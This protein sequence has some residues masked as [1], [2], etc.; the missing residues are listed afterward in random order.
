MIMEFSGIF[1]FVCAYVTAVATPGPG[2]AA[3]VARALGRGLQGIAPFILGF[4]IGDLVWFAVAAAG[5]AVL[6]QSFAVAF[7]VVKYCGAAY[8]LVLA[9]K[10][11][12]APVSAE[13][14]NTPEGVETGGRLFLA[15]LSL[16]LGNPKVI[17][18]FLALLPAIV[19]LDRLKLLDFLIISGIIAVVISAT[20][21]AYA[22]AASRARRFFRS[23][24]ALKRLNRL[25]GSVMAGVAAVIVA[26]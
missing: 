26:R 23:P 18:F 20:M 17:V 16:T 25:T 11:W 15:S 9:Y 13:P 4:V 24:K 7:L 12:T 3:V 1:L 8:L 6:A 22:L 10:L 21:F 14:V 19:S 5:L 2:V